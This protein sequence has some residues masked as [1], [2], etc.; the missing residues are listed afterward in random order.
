M[1]LEIHS[2]LPDLKSACPFAV[3]FK[4]LDS[5]I[6]LVFLSGSQKAGGRG[7]VSLAHRGL[8]LSKNLLGAERSTRSWTSSLGTI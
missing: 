3:K 1:A 7:E 2:E 5:S 8:T 4:W 6:G